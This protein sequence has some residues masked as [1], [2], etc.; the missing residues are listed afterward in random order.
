M[1]IAIVVADDHQIVRDGLRSLLNQESD[2]QVVGEAEDG[3]STVDMVTLE[4][5]DIVVMDVGMPG[6][7]GIEATR[8][9]MSQVPDVKVVALSMHTDKRFVGGMLGAGARAY[10]VKQSAFDELA[11][12]IR[13]VLNGRV[14]LSQEIAGVVIEDYI[15]NLADSTPSQQSSPLTTRER[16]VLQL[17]A[18]GQS[19]QQIATRLH[20]SAKTVGTHREHI[21][22]KLNRHSIAELTQYAL[23]EGLVVWDWADPPME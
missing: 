18:E 19:T 10:L 5:P 13:E 2:F 23:R 15:S 8:Q 1:S 3:R 17:L 4:K 11:R 12:A 9:I 20:V 22:Q 21:M 16:E 14:Y 7:N 6:L